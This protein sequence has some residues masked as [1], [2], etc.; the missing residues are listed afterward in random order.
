MN[1]VWLAARTL[2]MK[3]PETDIG[4]VMAEPVEIEWARRPGCWRRRRARDRPPMAEARAQRSV[5]LQGRDRR[6]CD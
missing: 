6:G 3:L 5:E 4:C 2:G 1:A